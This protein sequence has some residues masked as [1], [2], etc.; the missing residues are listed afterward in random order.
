MT[1]P[2]KDDFVPGDVLGSAQVNNIADNLNLFNPT[3]A[4]NGQVWIA[5]GSGSGAYATP[6]SGGITVL[7]SGSLSTS[8]LDLTSISASYKALELVL[9]DAN[10]STTNNWGLQLNGLTGPTFGYGA[11]RQYGTTNFNQTSG[12]TF[13]LDAGTWGSGAI[14]QMRFY[15]PFYSVNRYQLGFYETITRT[16]AIGGYAVFTYLDAQMIINRIR[17]FSASGA[18]FTAG[19]YELRGIK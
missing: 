15:F 17:I 5:N 11:V 10:F 12:T 18:T 19:T 3:A 9:M 16:S 1:W 13:G 2:T 14:T 7:A 8:A 6:A 4:T